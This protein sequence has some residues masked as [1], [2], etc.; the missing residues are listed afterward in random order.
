MPSFLFRTFC[1]EASESRAHFHHR[2]CI[3]SLILRQEG[4][5]PRRRPVLATPRTHGHRV[6]CTAHA[7]LGGVSFSTHQPDNVPTPPG[8]LLRQP[9]WLVT[10]HSSVRTS[11]RP[12]HATPTQQK[13]KKRS[14]CDLKLVYLSGGG[15]KQE[16]T[17]LATC[18]RGVQQSRRYLFTRTF[19]MLLW[20]THR[21]GTG[22][23]EIGY[24][25]S[26]RHSTEANSRI[27]KEAKDK[28]NS[29]RSRGIFKTARLNLAPLRL[30]R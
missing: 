11:A 14:T 20:H 24:K 28:H 2:S 6:G 23:T 26:I 29:P 18:Y 27:P 22:C 3:S 5:I 30:Q 21:G 16:L 15:C 13:S 7:P 12:V 17:F 25:V 19:W 4:A 9:A 8:T 1:F 10:R